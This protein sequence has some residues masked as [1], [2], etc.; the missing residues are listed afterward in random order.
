MMYLANGVFPENLSKTDK[1][2]ADMVIDTA[3]ELEEAASGDYAQ[4]T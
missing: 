1:I 3:K 2:L 4:L